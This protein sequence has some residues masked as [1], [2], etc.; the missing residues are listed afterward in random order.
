MVA[1]VDA[2]AVLAVYFDEAGAEQV[3]MA[4]PGAL[5]S[6]VNYTEVIGKCLEH[7][8][9][10]VSLRKLAA[11]GVEIV[12]HD[13]AI[14]A[15]RRRIA[16]CHQTPRSFACRSRMSGARGARNTLPVLT[17]DRKWA[18]VDLGIDIHRHPLGQWPSRPMAATPAI[19][20]S[21]RRIS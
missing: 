18:K 7:G 3:R 2:S 16:A 11:M 8:E 14:G 20:L 5:F 17:A 15:A 13:A 9:T 1:V 6:A 19:N 21:Q 10:R 12:A 4:L